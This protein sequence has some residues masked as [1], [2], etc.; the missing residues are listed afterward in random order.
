MQVTVTKRTVQFSVLSVNSLALE[1]WS[2]T[3]KRLF[4]TE[5]RT[6]PVYQAT[7]LFT[8][9]IYPFYFLVCYPLSP[10]TWTMITHP[11]DP[12]NDS[13]HSPT[14]NFLEI[15]S[16]GGHNFGL[17]TVFK[18]QSLVQCHSQIF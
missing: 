15:L 4:L 5:D 13:R 10:F 17:Y 16:T 8:E 9:A 2:E 1:R 12:Q 14:E 7:N 6:E 3:P 18:N 11:N